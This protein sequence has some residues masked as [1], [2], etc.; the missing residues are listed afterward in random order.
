M[1]IAAIMCGG[2]GSR[3]RQ[4]PNIEK[5]LL[6]I[7]DKTMIENIL[8]ALIASKKFGRIVGVSSPNT[9]KTSTF[10]GYCSPGIIDVIETEGIS[11]SK[12]LSVV[13]EPK[14]GHGIC[15]I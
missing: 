15:S 2:K 3:I 8:H 7:K 12:D 5:P 9:P 6:K 13:Q 4:S 14:T 11:Y 10:L 1:M